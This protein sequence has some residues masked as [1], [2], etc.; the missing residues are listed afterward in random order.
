MIF[1]EDF[2]SVF[3]VAVTL[4]CFPDQSINKNCLNI[5]GTQNSTA[6]EL[7]SLLYYSWECLVPGL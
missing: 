3:L 2:C 7:V 4:W 1:F 5:A 6:I